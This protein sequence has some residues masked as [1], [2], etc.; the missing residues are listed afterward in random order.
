MPAFITGIGLEKRRVEVPDEDEE[1]LKPED[2]PA[3]A[4]L[5]P[6]RPLEYGKML[7]DVTKLRNDDSLEELRQMIRRTGEKMESQKKV[8]N[9]FISDVHQI[10]SLQRSFSSSDIVLSDEAAMSGTALRHQFKL[11]VQQKPRIRRQLALPSQNTR[12]QPLRGIAL[13]DLGH[14]Q[15]QPVLSKSSPSNAKPVAA[16][17]FT[18]LAM[19]PRRAPPGA[20]GGPLDADLEV[21]RHL[22][23]AHAGSELTRPGS[24]A[25]SG[26]LKRRSGSVP[27]GLSA[28]VRSH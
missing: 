3:L 27:S 23:R 22:R 18:P 7:N 19:P 15:S 28:A 20:P 4:Y 1:E 14:S 26:N 8:L 24:G 9:G 5:E 11:M 13:N 6:P 16:S 17:S 10:Q 21:R 25:S 12:D 2:L